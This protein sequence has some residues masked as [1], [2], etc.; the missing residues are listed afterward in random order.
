MSEDRKGFIWTDDEESQ[1]L[2]EI[3]RDISYDDICTNHKRTIGGIKSRLK[4]IAVR[5]YYEKKEM[6]EIMQTTRLNEFQVT[7]ALEKYK[8]KMKQ[9]FETKKSEGSNDVV[10]KNDTMVKELEL[11][12][13]SI[14]LLQ[15]H[16]EILEMKI[17]MKNE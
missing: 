14:E 6:K 12:R 5:M 2:A 16:I 11:I 4:M 13:K 17:D 10:I 1:L 15:K 3:K 9:S 7:E 8:Q